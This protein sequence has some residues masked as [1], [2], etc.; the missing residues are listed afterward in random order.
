MSDQDT[1]RPNAERENFIKSKMTHDKNYVGMRSRYANATLIS[2]IKDTK[3][4]SPLIKPRSPTHK[5]TLAVRIKRN[6]MELQFWGY[7]IGNVLAT[8]AGAG[9]FLSF[10]GTIQ[11]VLQNQS[12]GAFTAIQ[13]LLTRFPDVTVTIGL[14][15]L[16]LIVPALRARVFS[17]WS[18]H[19]LNVTDISITII[20]LAI[21]CYAIILDTS[22]IAIASSC[23]VLASCF[24]RQCRT[25]PLLIKAG[26]LAL[27]CG[28]I[29][30]VLYGLQVALPVALDRGNSVVIL[31]TLTS[32]TG[33]Y[34]MFAGLLTY[35]GGIFATRD[36]ISQDVDR[37][38]D[39]WLSKLTHPLNGFLARRVIAHTDLPI[40][41]LNSRISRPAIFWVSG[42]TKN[43]QPFKTSMLARLPWRVLT[44]LAALLTLTPT[45]FAF[46]TANVC[47]AFGDIAIGSEDW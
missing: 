17:K 23:F 43:N 34:V 46:F 19:W 39:V 10:A 24:L 12:V 30:L 11:T 47:W 37:S 3:T 32:V 33:I 5:S 15:T 9:G 29:G 6:N 14:G 8:V 28:G 27:A 21:L 35:E 1:K 18:S 26:G 4:T 13:Q 44:G 41:I 20:A 40:L 2:Q 42:F 7:E 16:V 38:D 36:Y 25:N 45:G 22:W 31:G